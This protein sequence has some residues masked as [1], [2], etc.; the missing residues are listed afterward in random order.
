MK[1]LIVRAVWL[2]VLLVPMKNRTRYLRRDFE[3]VY[4]N[5]SERSSWGQYIRDYPL[6]KEICC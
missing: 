3:M 6:V 1:A 5:M 2:E 4:I